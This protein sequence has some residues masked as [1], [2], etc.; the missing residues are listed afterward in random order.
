MRTATVRK[1]RTAQQACRGFTLIELLVVIAVIA[2][3]AGML[4]PAVNGAMRKAKEKATRMEIGTLEVA[5]LAYFSDW[6]AY[7]PDRGA[8]NEN[9]TPAS[10]DY[11]S[12]QCLVYYLGTKFRA[13]DG[14]SRNGGTYFE[15]PGDRLVSV[16]VGTV[17]AD[18][19]MDR[20]KDKAGRSTSGKTFYYH[21]DNND[22][23]DGDQTTWG[24]WDSYNRNA[25][26]VNHSKVDI[27]STG[28]NGEDGVLARHLTK[29]DVADENLSTT[30]P[31]SV[32]AKLKDDIGNWDL[33]DKRK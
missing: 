32:W 13:S 4:M 24:N 33:A 22:A 10:R 5:L 7:P 20:L 9:W 19:F 30:V 31:A 14:F 17:T 15:F 3:L 28:W 23:E 2:I 6:G 18:V 21:C 8:Y 16:T 29:D 26:N 11:N 12:G 25:S 1:P 27:W